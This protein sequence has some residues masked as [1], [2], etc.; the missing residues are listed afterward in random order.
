MYVCIQCYYYYV[1]SAISYKSHQTLTLT[2]E[3]EIYFHFLSNSRCR[4][5]R[6]GKRFQV[7]SSQ[8]KG[9][10]LEPSGMCVHCTSVQYIVQLY[11]NVCGVCM[12]TKNMCAV[13]DGSDGSFSDNEVN[14]Q[15]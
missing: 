1:K 8:D 6:R 2:R 9:H 12:R 10:Y 5:R 11:L 15:V 14:K 3:T 7:R 4:R 13:C